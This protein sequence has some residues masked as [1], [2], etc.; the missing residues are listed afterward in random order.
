[1]NGVPFEKA[2]ELFLKYYRICND[3]NQSKE[4]SVLFA[5]KFIDANED[6][7]YWSEVINEISCIEQ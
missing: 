6:V 5:Q 2:K 4:S 3:F 1:M 7:E